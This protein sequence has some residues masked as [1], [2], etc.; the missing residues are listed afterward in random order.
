VVVNNS[1]NL[2]SPK[3]VSL[4]PSR[5]LLVSGDLA[6]GVTGLSEFDLSGRFI[7]S[8]PTGAAGGGASSVT[9]NHSL[10]GFG[11]EVVQLNANDSTIQF[12]PIT[13]N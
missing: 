6:S 1:P 8:L 4:S 12:L 7:G 5:T 13:Q 2:T 9:W 3:G 11:P 10:Y